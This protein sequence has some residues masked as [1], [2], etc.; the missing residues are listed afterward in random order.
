RPDEER[1]GL[2]GRMRG[3]RALVALDG[4]VEAAGHLMLVRALE[5]V[6]RVVDPSEVVHGSSRQDSTPAA[7]GLAVTRGF[8]YA[9]PPCGTAGSSRLSSPRCSPA[10]RAPRASRMR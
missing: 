3:D 1:V 6:T 5:L 8:R 9:R 7:E 4:L 10:A 2:G